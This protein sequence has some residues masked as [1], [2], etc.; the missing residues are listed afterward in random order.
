M[1]ISYLLL[2]RM[3]QLKFIIFKKKQV[4]E[5]GNANQTIETNIDINA[6]LFDSHFFEID[7]IGTSKGLH[8]RKIKGGAKP[9]FKWSLPFSCL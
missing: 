7:A 5:E 3:E 1:E 6:I 9:I 2:L 4:L 8:I